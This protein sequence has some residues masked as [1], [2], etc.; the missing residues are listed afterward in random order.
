MKNY[1]NLDICKINEFVQYDERSPSGLI[2]I[3]KAFK[4]NKYRI[5]SWKF[6]KRW[7]LETYV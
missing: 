1:I 2:W 7:V 4:K 3:K 5:Y 6:S